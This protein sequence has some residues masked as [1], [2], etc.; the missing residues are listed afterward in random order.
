MNVMKKTFYIIASA[1]AA[2]SCSEPEKEPVLPSDGAAPEVQSVTMS[3]GIDLQDPDE[4]ISIEAG[5]IYVLYDR[6]VSVADAASITLNDVP[7]NT[8][9]MNVRIGIE[10][11]ELEYATDYTLNIPAGAVVSKEAGTPAESLTLAFRTESDP[12]ATFEPGT[13][14]DY[15][16][17]LVTADPINNAQRL[18]SYL[19]SIYGQKTLS[20]AMAEVDWN[21]DEADWINRYTGKYPAIASFDYLHLRSSEEGSWINYGDIEVVE[22]WFAANGIVSACWHWNVPVSEGSSETTST[23]S[24]TVFSVSNIFEEGTWEYE[25]AHEDLEKIAG[26]LKLLQEKNIPVIWRPLHEAAGNRYE[27]QGGEAWFWWGNEGP[28]QFIRLWKYMFD[29]FE[30]EGIRN[31]IWVWTTQTSVLDKTDYAYYPGDDYV[32][33]VSRD[34]YGNS[35]VEYDSAQIEDQFSTVASMVPHKMVALSELGGLPDMAQQWNAGARWLFFMPWYDDTD[36]NVEPEDKYTE[37][38]DH[39]HADIDWWT[40]TFASDAVVTRDELP[41]NLYQR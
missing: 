26:Y 24:A 31:L 32:D 39:M 35:G 2:F 41:E 8:L 10:F 16:D 23:A 12:N 15:A 40:A 6:A 28:D 19:L 33:I 21:T 7:L 37:D 5:T 29:Y 34:I 4:L 1:L 18:Y 20:S 14:G 17:R 22:D 30:S 36:V 27:Y 9:G 38:F 13:P 11:G 3:G 25:Y